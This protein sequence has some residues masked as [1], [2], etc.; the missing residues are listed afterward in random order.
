MFPNLHLLRNPF[1]LTPP[2]SVSPYDV[3]V[4]FQPAHQLVISAIKTLLSPHLLMMMMVM[5]MM[6]NVH[7]NDDV[8]DGDD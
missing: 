4:R 8:H 3:C 1:L 7:D 6:I 5:M 2:D